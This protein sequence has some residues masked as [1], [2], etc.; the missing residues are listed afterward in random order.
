MTHELYSFAIDL[1]QR[2]GKNTLRYFQKTFDIHQKQD[3]SPVT[4]ADRS[5]EDFMREEIEKRF[6][7]DAILG[8]EFAEKQGSSGYRWILDP[9]D[10]TESFIRGV[11]LYGTMMALEREGDSLFGV[12]HYPAT[13]DTLRALKEDGC[14]FNDEPCSVSRTQSFVQAIVTTT[15]LHRFHQLWGGPC[16][17][18]I[19][20]RTASLRTWGCFAFAVVATGRADLF[21]EPSMK[22]WD[23][24]PAIPII[25]EA[26]GLLTDRKGDTHLDIS[27]MIA[28]N[29]NLHSEMVHLINETSYYS[30]YK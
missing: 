16:L 9:I 13:G 23:T 14:F 11:P 24:A 10:G 8:E 2:A 20:E 18:K 5:T 19:I 26:G 12:I 21:I 15:S 7:R 25:M 27:C 22:A 6:P 3:T 29:P 4:E 1:A 28:G 17:A 30:T